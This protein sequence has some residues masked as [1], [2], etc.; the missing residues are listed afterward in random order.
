MS[1]S[2]LA[3]PEAWELIASGYERDVVPIFR[4]FVEEA[5]RLAA[6]A[7]GARIV[8]VAAGP[9][10]LSLLAAPTAARV[11][12]VDFAPAMIARLEARAREAGLDNVFAKVADGQALPFAD[13]GF[14][15]AFSLFGVIFFPDRG[16]G[17]AELSRVVRRG[18]AVVVSSWPPAT[19]VMAAVFSALREVTGAAPEPDVPPALGDAPS[20]AREFAAAGLGEVHVEQVANAVEVASVDELLTAQEQSLAPLALLAKRAGGGWPALRAKMLAA[21][22]AR[23]GD[24]RL[25]ID[26][27]ALVGVGRKR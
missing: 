27:P 25:V 23:L 12:A 3:L 14:D 9:G 15:A 24:G 2:P 16:R 10:T 1:A 26:L 20:F 22:R 8:D 19:G 18:A 11:D 21:M 7:P 6:L 13:G 5:L 4:P 17:L